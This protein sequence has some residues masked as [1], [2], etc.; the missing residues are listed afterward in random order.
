MVLRDV[1]ARW[2][3]DHGVRAHYSSTPFEWDRFVDDGADRLASLLERGGAVDLVI[4]PGE[5][6]ALAALKL[7]AKAGLTAGQDIMLAACADAQLLRVCDPPVT[8]ID[9][10]PRLLGAACAL[11]LVN[12]LDEGPPLAELALLPATLV[13]RA[14][15]AALNGRAGR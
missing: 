10:S 8:A 4:V 2:C 13:K 5:Y 9:L 1:F 6:A 12:H 11:A 14:S 3:A 15:T 7:I